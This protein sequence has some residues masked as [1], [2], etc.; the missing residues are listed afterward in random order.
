MQLRKKLILVA[1]LACA[2]ALVATVAYAA[3]GVKF[4][5]T[6][7]P[8]KAGKP[9]GVG[10]NFEASDPA[11]QQPPI[12]NKIV[13]NFAKGG[14]WNGAKFPKCSTATLLSKG[15]GGCPSKS[16]IGS[17]T[18][19][20]YAKPVVTDPVAAKLTIFNG[21]SQILV[22]VLPDLGPT[23]VTPCKITGGYN[24]T[25]TI[26]PIKTLPSAP[27]ASVGTV[28]TKTKA[29][30]IKKSGKKVGLVIAPKKCAGSWKSSAS[31][32]FATGEIVKTTSTQK[33]KK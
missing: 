28:K 26:P 23:F 1:V 18:G 29:V 32:Y 15:P 20:G 11:A 2:A 8:N 24:L 30:T 19:V 31:F 25:C 10:V 4:S 27:D 9:T 22:F 3:V 16:K 13:I 5:S 33:C 21:G 7:S 12:M 6:F 17:G 14:K